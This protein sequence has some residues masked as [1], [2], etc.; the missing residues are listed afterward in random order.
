MGQ[1]DILRVPDGT[2]IG[3]P[4]SLNFLPPHSLSFSIG[5]VIKPAFFLTVASWI[6]FC[7]PPSHAFLRRTQPIAFAMVKPIAFF[8]IPHCVDIQ[9]SSIDRKIQQPPTEKSWG[10]FLRHSTSST[11]PHPSYQNAARL[12]R[13]IT[14]VQACIQGHRDP[15]NTCD[16]HICT[17]QIWGKA[18]W[19]TSGAALGRVTDVGGGNGEQTAAAE[20]ADKLVG[21][22]LR[23]DYDITKSRE[24]YIP[25]TY[26]RVL[27]LGNSSETR[28]GTRM[29]NRT[30][31]RILITLALRESAFTFNTTPFL[32]HTANLIVRSEC[33]PAL[34]HQGM[35]ST[36][37]LVTL[38]A[39][40]AFSIQ[41]HQDPDTTYDA[42]HTPKLGGGQGVGC[43][44]YA[45]VP[46]PQIRASETVFRLPPMTVESDALFV[47][48]ECGTNVFFAVHQSP[49]TST[50]VAKTGHHDPDLG[51]DED[52]AVVER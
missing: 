48:I 47:L 22:Q 20:E 11:Q 30:K 23:S 26:T 24:T 38:N 5:T 44:S 35:V 7:V 52:S 36:L 12:F 8:Q 17:F 21:L 33:S 45:S 49:G 13:G 50:V 18:P 31:N 10:F 9:Q 42:S 41:G 51:A 37:R 29:L 28:R 46:K 1:S 25:E 15:N 14:S 40:K 16:V 27:D 6:S 39:E 4:V 34:I 2:G 3:I 32:S 19:H 43:G